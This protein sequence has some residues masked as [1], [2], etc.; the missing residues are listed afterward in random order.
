[1][2]PV[3]KKPDPA[4]PGQNVEK[5]K[6]SDRNNNDHNNNGENCADHV[7]TMINLNRKTI[8]VVMIVRAKRMMI[9]TFQS[10]FEIIQLSENP[11]LILSLLL[12]LL[13]LESL[14]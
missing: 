4:V 1:M 6:F 3:K 11:I 5:C 2:I 13:L 14:V 8:M 9:E 10:L 12:L 7:I